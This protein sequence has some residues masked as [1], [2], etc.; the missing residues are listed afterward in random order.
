MTTLKNTSSVRTLGETKIEPRAE[1]FA[2]Q[3]KSSLSATQP[4]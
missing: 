3:E 2:L 1:L 4:K